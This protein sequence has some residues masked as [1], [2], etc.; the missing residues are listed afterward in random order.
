L[1]APVEKTSTD[2]TSKV[3]TAP[4]THGIRINTLT[5]IPTEATFK[6]EKVISRYVSRGLEGVVLM[7]DWPSHR[8]TVRVG[9][10]TPI[11]SETYEDIFEVLK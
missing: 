3:S 8:L 6:K 2:I 5:V 10:N 4:I 9:Y 1:Q 7:Y 11:F